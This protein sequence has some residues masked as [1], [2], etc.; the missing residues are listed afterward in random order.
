MQDLPFD[1]THVD[2]QDIK[3][4]A[5]T[6]AALRKKFKVAISKNP[7]FDPGSFDVL[8]T[9]TGV[10]VGGTLLINHP[11]SGCYLVF[12]KVAAGVSAQE[13]FTYQVW[14]SATLRN[15]FGKMSIRRET[16]VDKIP[17][18]ADQP[19]MYFKDD[20][21]FSKKFNV[22]ADNRQKAARAMTK[23]FRNVINETGKTDWEIE[24]AG[25]SLVMGSTHPV[26]PRQV[27]YLAETASKFSKVK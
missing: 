27:V 9:Q 3:L 25:S 6:Y 24:I 20:P 10:S 2:D 23:A 19:G 18:A 21:S 14:A 15:D 4:L 1:I 17:N 12:V 16:L 7:A 11:E 22:V 8:N 5:D 13:I 26:E